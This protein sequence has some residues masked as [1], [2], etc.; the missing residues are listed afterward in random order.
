[1]DITSK[2]TQNASDKIAVVKYVGIFAAAYFALM[3]GIA[4]FL[5]VFDLDGNSGT[6]IASVMG[7]VYLA[8]AKFVSD[9]KRRPTRAEALMLAAWSLVAS[10]VV[11][12]LALLVFLMV[13]GGWQDLLVIINELG[14]GMLAVISV[15]VALCYFFVIWFFYNFAAKTQLNALQKRG[16]L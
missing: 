7:A 14:A 3:M 5:S 9:N 16:K 15:I 2:A 4:I 6:S 10:F 13:A 1:M 12:G 11:S 8:A